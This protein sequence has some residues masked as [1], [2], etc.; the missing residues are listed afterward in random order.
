MKVTLS[1]DYFEK[2]IAHEEYFR[3]KYTGAYFSKPGLYTKEG[4][5]ISVA[6]WAT[7]GWT[8]PVIFAYTH[9]ISLTS[10]D[11]Q[12]FLF[13]SDDLYKFLQSRYTLTNQMSEPVAHIVLEIVDFISNPEEEEKFWSALKDVPMVG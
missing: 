5:I 11:G 7:P 13:A 2:Y 4:K 9:Y 6:P 10:I 12:S 8:S 1:P 3:E